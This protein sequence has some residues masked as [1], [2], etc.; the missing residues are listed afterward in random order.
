MNENE[1]LDTAIDVSDQFYIHRVFLTKIESKLVKYSSCTVKIFLPIHI[2]L[3][4]LL[5]WTVFIPK[6]CL[7]SIYMQKEVSESSESN[8]N[9]DSCADGSFYD[10]KKDSQGGWMVCTL[11]IPSRT[12]LPQA[13]RNIFKLLQVFRCCQVFVC[14]LSAFLSCCPLEFM[15]RFVYMMRGYLE[16]STSSSF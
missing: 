1:V 8:K 15:V 5:Q 12:L 14:N 2:F 10:S 3:L 11:L 9:G 7:R 16:S 13:F 6:S 4:N